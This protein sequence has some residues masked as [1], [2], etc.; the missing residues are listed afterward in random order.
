MAPDYH[1]KG[2]CADEPKECQLVHVVVVVVVVAVSAAAVVV[3]AYV[4][5][6]QRGNRWFFGPKL[7]SARTSWPPL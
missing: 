1:Y 4:V 2:N 6:V 5:T 3:V 7:L